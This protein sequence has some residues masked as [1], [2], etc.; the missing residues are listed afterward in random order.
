MYGLWSGYI[1]VK[2]KHCV[3]TIA[4]ELRPFFLKDRSLLNCLFSAVRS[5]ILD[6]DYFL[7]EDDD[8]ENEIDEEGF[9]LF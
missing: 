3:F 4:E 9:Y 2:H 5:V 6:M 7:D 1:H 8:L